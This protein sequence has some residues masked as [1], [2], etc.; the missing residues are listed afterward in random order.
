MPDKQT[1]AGAGKDERE[2]NAAS[3]RKTGKTKGSA[4]RSIAAR[5]AARARIMRAK[6]H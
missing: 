6:A 4:G 1:L 2:G 3:A 5:K